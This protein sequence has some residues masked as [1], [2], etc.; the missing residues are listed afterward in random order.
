MKMT[1]SDIDLYESLLA[2]DEADRRLR[3]HGG[4]LLLVTGLLSVS[5]FIFGRSDGDAE[6]EPRR[7]L[8][9]EPVVMITLAGWGIGIMLQFLESH[10]KIDRQ[11]GK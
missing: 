10:R 8:V 4:I 5:R 6:E 11:I 2:R 3:F 9:E 7:G 1:L